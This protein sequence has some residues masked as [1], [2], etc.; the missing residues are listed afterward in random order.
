MTEQKAIRNEWP[1]IIDILHMQ[2]VIWIYCPAHAGDDR[3]K[4]DQLV[5]RARLDGLIKMDT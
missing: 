2:N 3:N 5:A 4:A 1:E